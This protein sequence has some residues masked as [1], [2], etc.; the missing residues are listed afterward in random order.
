[1]GGMG[2]GYFVPEGKESFF[3]KLEGMTDKELAEYNVQKKME[4]NLRADRVQY[5]AYKRVMGED[6]V[7][8][9]AE[10]RDVKYNGA[11]E[12]YEG[13]KRRDREVS[14]GK[15]IEAQG[16][17]KGNAAKSQSAGI[18]NAGISGGLQEVAGR[19]IINAENKN[20]L[21]QALGGVSV[22]KEYR[23]KFD[24]F[25][26]LSISERE[27]GILLNL[28]DVS[29]TDGFEH[30][31]VVVGGELYEFTSGIA[32]KV[33]IPEDVRSMI[34]AAPER[35]VHLLHNHT[36]ETPHSATDLEWVLNAGVDRISVVTHSKSVYSVYVGDGYMPTQ[37]E[38]QEAVKTI[39]KEVDADL[40]NLPGY[41]EWT[42]DERNY[43]GIREQ[44]Y[45]I[46]R[47]FKWTME[48]GVL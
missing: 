23:G 22:P 35:S 11:G 2:G 47:H 32:D 30:G 4:R 45:R 34:D 24:D 42:L 16:E 28:L 29:K 7:G 13:L 31:A 27:K 18:G 5:G 33:S 12:G 48:G 36:N 3:R 17:S 1:M 38:F 21:N 25:I 40:R 10:F 19:G 39:I 9:F 43:A 6:E 26:P 37:E 20:L 44:T 41:D 46:I 14:R 8:T 15:R